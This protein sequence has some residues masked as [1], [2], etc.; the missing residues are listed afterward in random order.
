LQKETTQFSLTFYAG[1]DSLKTQSNDYYISYENGETAGEA[2]SVNYERQHTQFYFF[3][4]RSIYRPGQTVYFKAI[5]ITSDKNTSKPKLSEID[6]VKLLLKDV[7]G[8][9]ID[10]LSLSL[11]DYGSVTGSFKLPQSALTG[12]FNIIVD[13]YSAMS[14]F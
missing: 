12:N 9:E 14:Q 10:T 2:D 6:K 1:R 11:N 4:D 13:N 3:T 7:N 8:K 5:A